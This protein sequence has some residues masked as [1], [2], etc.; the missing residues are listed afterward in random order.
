MYIVNQFGSSPIH[1]AA[2]Q[3]QPLSLYYL[4]KQGVDINL[5][6][7]K[8][9]APLHWACFTRSET[10]LNY[11][12]SLK[13]DLEAK[14]IFGQTALHIAVTCV[15]K[16]GSCR[17][18]K[19]L[20]LRGADRETKDKKGKTPREIIPENMEEHR[21]DELYTYLKPPKFTECLMVRI[22]LVPLNR[23]HNTQILFISLFSVVSI[24][25]LIIILPTLELHLS[26]VTQV[27]N[28]VSTAFVFFMFLLA[29][30]QNPGILK[31]DEDK[32]F[33][34]LL[35]DINPAD[36][37]PECKLIRTARSRHCAICNQC[38]ERFDHHCPWINNCVGI[39]NHNTFMIFLFSIWIKICVTLYFDIDSLVVFWKLEEDF[40]C[41]QQHCIDVCLQKLCT[42]KYVHISSCFICIFICLFYLFL[43]SALLFTH[44]KN[45]AAARTTNERFAKK[46][47][48]EDEDLNQ[49]MLTVSDLDLSREG[50]GNSRGR[51]TAK[52]TAKKRSCFGN[53][54]RMCN[55]TKITSQNR[56]YNYLAEP[57]NIL[58]ESE[59]S[60]SRAAK[61]QRK[62]ISDN[63][64]SSGQNDPFS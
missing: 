2:Q 47:V 63:S 21:Q 48:I 4:W 52:R 44:L 54:W 38:V 42:N 43:S 22:P 58:S 6:D 33:M 37:C 49:S 53:C 45:Y 20:L 40:L 51:S 60:L 59:V 23:N 50:T 64:K 32:Q 1:I 24:L 7:Q 61:D 29:S 3:D 30:F 28:M 15:E 16:L 41:D 27:G 39:K 55:N 19:M 9:G 57:Q 56:L 12:L 36:L 25:N 8:G 46:P 14:D 62:L 31:P 34:E 11:I 35:N 5:R 26:N 13:P 18:V 17:N 10:A